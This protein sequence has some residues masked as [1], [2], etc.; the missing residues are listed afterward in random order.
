[1]EAGGWNIQFQHGLLDCSRPL[2]ATAEGILPIKRGFV[3]P[4][5]EFG[6]CKYF[7]SKK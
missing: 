2:L 6:L 7:G 4:F 3:L 5:V 1:M